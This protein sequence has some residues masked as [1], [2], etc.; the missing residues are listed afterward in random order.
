MYILIHPNVFTKWD[1][2]Q[3]DVMNCFWENR[4]KHF[5][6]LPDEDESKKSL[7]S[8]FYPDPGSGDELKDQFLSILKDPELKGVHYLLLSHVNCK[9]KIPSHGNL[10][11]IEKEILSRISSF[12]EYG[13]HPGILIIYP[14]EKNQPGDQISQEGFMKVL[15]NTWKGLYVTFTKDAQIPEFPGNRKYIEIHKLL[16]INNIWDYF[17]SQ[18]TQI[19]KQDQEIRFEE[20]VGRVL[21]NQYKIQNFSGGKYFKEQVDVYCSDINGMVI[22]GEC[23]L[24]GD[25]KVFSKN[26][27]YSDNKFQIRDKLAAVIKHERGIFLHNYP[28]SITI[29]VISNCEEIEEEAKTKLIDLGNTIQKEYQSKWNLSKFEIVYFFVQMPKTYRYNNSWKLNFGMFRPV[30]IFSS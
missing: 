7:I 19:I 25:G 11:N 2:N 18:N 26:N 14:G 17:R 1:E 28:I 5:L 12:C 13:N 20:E 6:L 23:K 22:V 30:K 21:S 9:A 24:L 4:S 15:S 27:L 10:N 8:P 16:E 29:A 3:V